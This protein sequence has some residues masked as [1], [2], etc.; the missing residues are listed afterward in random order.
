MK[1]IVLTLSLFVVA[2]GTAFSQSTIWNPKDI[3]VDTS[4]GIRY[5]SAIDTNIVWGIAYDGTTASN[6]ATNT[7]VRTSN[8]G[9]FTKG[10]FL[11][12]TNTYNAS[13]IIALDSLTAYVAVYEKA[14]DGRSGKIVKTVDGGVHWTNASDTVT[15]FAGSANFPDFVYFWDHNNGLALGDPNGNTG[16]GSTNEF[17]IWRTHNAGVNWTRVPDANI[18][19]PLSAEYGLTNSY[20]TYGKRMWFGTEKGRVYSS[21]DSGQTWTVNT[22]NIGLAGGVQG[23]AFRDSL[24]GICWGLATTTATQNTLKKTSNGG[25]TWSAVTMDPNNT[26][27]Y[28]FCTVPGRNSYMSVGANSAGSGYVTSVTPDD[29]VTWNLLETGTTNAFRMIEV[30]MLDSAHGWAGSF[31][32]TSST[33]PL[34]KG[35]MNKYFGPKVAQACPINITSTKSTICLND[36]TKLT[37]LG[38]NTYTWSTAATT[39]NITVH[40]TTTT[41]YTVT[42]VIPGC[43]ST[44]TVNVTVIQTANPVVM[45]SNTTNTVCVGSQIVLGVSATPTVTTTYSWTPSASLSSATGASVYAHPVTTTNYTVYGTQGSCKSYATL[46]VTVNPTPGPTV[47]VNSA[48]FCPTVASVSLTANGATTYSWTPATGLSSTTGASVAASP[49]ATTVYMVTGTTGS[50]MSTMPSTVVVSPCTGI[51]QVSNTSKISVYP[52]PSNGMITISVPE[53]KEGTVMYVTD[54]IGKEVFKAS[55][56]DVNT[57][58]N[59][60]GLQKGMYMM[61]IVNGQNTQVEKLIIQQ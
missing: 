42:G 16:G 37:A 19:N 59:L 41:A 29:G 46:T 9:T 13:N 38:A 7:F 44:Q 55:I 43:T 53:V 11:P 49:T 52:N 3:N 32:D 50:C 40:P 12:D 26:G 39:S 45:V 48:T 24:N 17:E 28:A 57:L 61:T 34:G 8:G 4:W 18:P 1:K 31:T 60:S 10:S 33:R 47:T 15:M 20:T 36:S 58:V 2:T 54:M 21:L 5:M 14:G 56:H 27:L 25:L 51:A 30:Q 23:L 6:R 35:G 22:G